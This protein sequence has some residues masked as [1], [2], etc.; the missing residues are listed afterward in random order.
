LGKNVSSYI[1]KTHMLLWFQALKDAEQAVE[2]GDVES[3][4]KIL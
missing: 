3:A 1:I 4:F 2:R